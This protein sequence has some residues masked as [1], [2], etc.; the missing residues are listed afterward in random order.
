MIPSSQR[1]ASHR[2]RHRPCFLWPCCS[3]LRAVIRRVWR[4]HPRQRSSS[5]WGPGP[6][7]GGIGPKMGNQWT[8]LRTSNVF[9]ELHH[10]ET[11][12]EYP[13]L[14][15]FWDDFDVSVVL[16][17]RVCLQMGYEI[18]WWWHDGTGIGFEI[19][20]ETELG[21]CQ[22]VDSVNSRVPVWIDQLPKPKD[23]KHM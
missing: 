9:I 16:F 15:D 5:A 2:A 20:E 4:C 1:N 14:V 10:D 21:N 22:P 23:G 17:M 11:M 6:G 12:L 7:G 18:K 8:H 19:L 13:F 3:T